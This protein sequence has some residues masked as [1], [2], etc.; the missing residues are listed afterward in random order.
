MQILPWDFF[1]DLQDAL[2]SIPLPVV[3]AILSNLAPNEASLPTSNSPASLTSDTTKTALPCAFPVPQMN[4]I[5]DFQT[6]N[7][8]DMQSENDQGKIDKLNK[9]K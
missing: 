8:E 3:E 6:V 4:G 7:I 1:S 5:N 2:Q 9:V